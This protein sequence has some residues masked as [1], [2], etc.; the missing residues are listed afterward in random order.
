MN[1]DA[2]YNKVLG[3]TLERGLPANATVTPQAR[4]VYII[5]LVS[6]L[7]RRQYNIML[8]VPI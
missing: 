4:F 6:Q 7:F 8:C 1:Y 5:I 3:S 2:C